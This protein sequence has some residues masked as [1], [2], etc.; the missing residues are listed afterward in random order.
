MDG[1]KLDEDGNVVERPSCLLSGFSKENGKERLL[2]ILSIENEKGMTC[3][4]A[5]YDAGEF[6]NKMDDLIY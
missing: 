5:G 4:K 1:K 3:A 6:H 2:K